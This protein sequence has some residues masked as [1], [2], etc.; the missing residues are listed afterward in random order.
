MTSET[1][2]HVLTPADLWTLNTYDLTVHEGPGG[3]PC[4]F[5]MR[6]LDLVTQMMEDVTNA[7][8]MK[9]AL[10]VCAEVVAYQ[11]TH[12]GASFATAFDALGA[13]KKRL[14]LE[15]LRRFACS[16]VLTP[17]L[18]MPAPGVDLAAD[19]FPVTVL[20]TATLLAIWNDNPPPAVLAPAGI[21]TP[22]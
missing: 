13:D 15:Q 14:V 17:K 22:A 19:E 11:R 7:P 5:K 20:G 16:A 1:T 10:Q 6:R 8:M 18:V 21:G 3:Q 9:A 4:V 2:P 12:E